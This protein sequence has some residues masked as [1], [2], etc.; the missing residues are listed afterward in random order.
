M[1]KF[2]YATTI[3]FNMGYY[4]MLLEEQAKKITVY[5]AQLASDI[6]QK[7]NGGSFLQFACCVCLYE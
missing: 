4:S 7:K 6:F 3:D 5:S 1:E 2:R